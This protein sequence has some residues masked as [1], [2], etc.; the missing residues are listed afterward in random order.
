MVY[1]ENGAGEKRHSTGKCHGPALLLSPYG[2]K[3]RA[4]AHLGKCH[5]G[6]RREKARGESRRDVSG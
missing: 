6:W 1:G 2:T 3:A 4:I 5:R